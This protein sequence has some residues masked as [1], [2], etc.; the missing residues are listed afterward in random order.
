MKQIF[1]IHSN[2]LMNLKVISLPIGNGTTNK[3][4]M[5]ML[6]KKITNVRDE[7]GIL[8]RRELGLS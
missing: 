6:K 3:V 1:Q 7:K 2:Y 4:L 8:N 5:I